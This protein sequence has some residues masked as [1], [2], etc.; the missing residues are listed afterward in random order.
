MQASTR[1]FGLARHLYKTSDVSASYHIGRLVVARLK[2]VGLS[3]VMWEVDWTR[4]SNKKVTG[5]TLLDD[6]WECGD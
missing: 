1:E 3:R 4:R 5:R 6:C 2:E